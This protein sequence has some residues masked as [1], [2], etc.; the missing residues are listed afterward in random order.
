ME[1]R[2]KTCTVKWT[3]GAWMARWKEEN[4]PDVE[5]HIDLASTFRRTLMATCGPHISDR[6]KELQRELEKPDGDRDAI[7]QVAQVLSAC[8]HIEFAEAV[9]S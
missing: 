7:E 4:H 9:S 1:L 8:E 3:G 6:A 5:P 2:N